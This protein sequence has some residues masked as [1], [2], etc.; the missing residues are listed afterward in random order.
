M[1]NLG[2][3]VPLYTK[4]YAFILKKNRIIVSSLV[5]LSLLTGCSTT[6]TSSKSSVPSSE[7][8]ASVDE[9]VEGSIG[10][11]DTIWDETANE[12]VITKTAPDGTA[13]KIR[14]TKTDYAPIWSDKLETYKS[15]NTSAY[16]MLLNNDFSFSCRIK[17][18][19]DEEPDFVLFEA[20]NGKAVYNAINDS[21]YA[22]DALTEKEAYKK[23]VDYVDNE[24]DREYKEM[25]Y[26]HVDEYT[27]TP[28]EDGFDLIFSGTASGESW[29]GSM[30]RFW[31]LN[32]HI[33]FDG[34]WTKK[35][36][37]IEQPELESGGSASN[38]VSEWLNT[39]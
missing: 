38:A 27:I 31:T 7:F 10:D 28:T 2:R 9:A 4:G 13:K 33:D 30:Y 12:V 21:S 34:N 1:Y 6:A 18:F 19:S 8:I 25:R 14:M 24:V 3:I 35:D 15:A 16:A 5:I 36:L 26:N 39:L 29:N 37:K 32:A 22:A 11:A 23:A 17:I 20:I